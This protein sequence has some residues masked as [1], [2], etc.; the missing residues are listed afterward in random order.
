MEEQ[1]QPSY[2]TAE[3]PQAV[4]KPEEA[5][6][7]NEPASEGVE[8]AEEQKGQSTEDGYL[9]GF[10]FALVLCSITMVGFLFLLDVSI[11]STVCL[12]LGS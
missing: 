7:S 3:A 5:R 9:T 1:D 8:V 4:P 10:K 2:G 12:Y 6:K 11:V